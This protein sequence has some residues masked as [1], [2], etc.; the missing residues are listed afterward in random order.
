MYIPKIE[1]IQIY[2][3]VAVR[4][5]PL[6]GNDGWTEWEQCNDTFENTC[7]KYQ[8]ESKD[9]DCWVKYEVGEFYHTFDGKCLGIQRSKTFNNGVEV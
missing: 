4:N 7:Q 5:L 1:T 9:E 3:I 2:K 8:K 6:W